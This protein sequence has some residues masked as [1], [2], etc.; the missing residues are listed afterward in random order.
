ME[1]YEGQS[2]PAVC[3]PVHL[4]DH[5]SLYV[6]GREERAHSTAEKEYPLTSHTCR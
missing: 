5:G 6:T 3:F 4:S 2:R 1:V